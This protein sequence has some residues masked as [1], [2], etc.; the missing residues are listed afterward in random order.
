MAETILATASQKQV[1][2]SKYFQQYVGN[3]QNLVGTGSGSAN[4]LAGQGQSYANAVS[5][6]NNS[7]ASAAGNAGIAGANAINALIGNAFNAYGLGRGG[8]SF[9]GGG[10]AYN[11]FAP[12]IGG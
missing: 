12:G 6:N 5:A 10:A 4:A 7:A 8:S 9:G 11:A 2:M 1:W 3:L